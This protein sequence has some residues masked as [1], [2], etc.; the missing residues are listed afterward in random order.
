MLPLAD[1]NTIWAPKGVFLYFSEN[2]EIC[3]IGWVSFCENGVGVGKES[4]FFILVGGDGTHL[5]H[6]RRS[7]YAPPVHPCPLQRTRNDCARQGVAH[8]VPEPGQTT[9]GTT[10]LGRWARCT[11]PHLMPDRPRRADRT[12]GRALEGV[13]CVQNCADLDSA[14]LPFSTRKINQKNLIFLSKKA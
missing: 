8:G 5:P 9:Q 6:P 14:I 1:Y 4:A 13:E 11:G 12:G 7:L 10:T 3:T 2:L